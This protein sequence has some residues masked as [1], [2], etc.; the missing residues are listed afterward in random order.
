MFK[1]TYHH[2]DLS[3][4]TILVQASSLIDAIG[5]VCIQR[6]IDPQ[7]IL[8]VTRPRTMDVLQADTVRAEFRPDY[9]R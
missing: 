3:I 2:E 9:S 7:H 1:I 4:R 5:A 8:A 6:S